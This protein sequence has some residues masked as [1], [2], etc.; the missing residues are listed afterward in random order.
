LP[1]ADYANSPRLRFP[2][3][4]LR[5]DLPAKTWITG[6]VINGVARAY[7][8]DHLPD[9]QVVE[10]TVGG[11]TV[12]LRYDRASRHFTITDTGGT[13]VLHTPAYWF[14]WQ[15]FHPDTTVWQQGP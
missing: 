8:H 9:G 12:R 7:P 14:A 13:P 1:Y 10:D 15:A 3:S 4:F 5:E 11:M 2:V 6:V